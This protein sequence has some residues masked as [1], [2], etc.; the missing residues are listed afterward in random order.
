MRVTLTWMVMAHIVTVE[1][2]IL[3]SQSLPNKV[4]AGCKP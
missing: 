3:D 4:K 2:V 1:N